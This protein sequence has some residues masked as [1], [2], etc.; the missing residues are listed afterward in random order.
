MKTAARWFWVVLALCLACDRTTLVDGKAHLLVD[1]DNMDFGWYLV[2]SQA[3]KE[4]RLTNDGNTPLTLQDWDVTGASFSADAPLRTRL[5]SGESVVMAV[6]FSAMQAGRAEGTLAVRSSSNPVLVLLEGHAETSCDD[7]NVCTEDALAVD[8]A[9]AHTPANGACDDHSICTTLDRCSLG[10]CVGQLLNCDDGD[11]CTED[12]CGP[13]QGCSHTQETCDDDNRCT[14][15]F[16]EASTGCTHVPVSDGN[17]C[18][19]EP[20][21]CH[22]VGECRSG[23]CVE[24]PVL[25]GTQCSSGPCAVNGLCQ[26]GQC[27]GESPLDCDD[28]DLCTAD[29][30]DG[31]GGCSHLPITCYDSNPCTADTC[32]PEGGC[33]FGPVP[34]GA[35][36]T[37][38]A[39]AC[40]LGYQCKGGQCGAIFEN[41][42]TSCDDGFWCTQDTM[43]QAGHCGN[44]PETVETLSIYGSGEP[45]VSAD[46]RLLV[47]SDADLDVYQRTP[48]GYARVGTHSGVNT[49]G[50]LW[51]KAPD[52]PVVALTGGA[53]SV[54]PWA[55]WG[56]GASGDV[57]RLGSLPRSDDD[58]ALY[59]DAMHAWLFE[60][61][62][63]LGLNPN[64]Q[65]TLAIRHLVTGSVTDTVALSSPCEGVQV[66]ETRKQVWVRLSLGGVAVVQV[67][68]AGQVTGVRELNTEDE[69]NDVA[70]SPN[71][72][73]VLVTRAWLGYVGVELYDPETLALVSATPVEEPFRNVQFLAPDVLVATLYEASAA[74]SCAFNVAN[75][76]AWA[77]MG[78]TWDGLPYGARLVGD[79]LMEYF[80]ATVPRMG[81]VQWS[82]NGF[83]RT[84]I[85]LLGALSMGPLG[86]EGQS[87]ALSVSADA[88]LQVG[89]TPTLHIT[90]V[91]VPAGRMLLWTDP[92]HTRTTNS[93]T[94]LWS[95]ARTTPPHE[96]VQED[97]LELQRRTQWSYSQWFARG[98]YAY[99]AVPD[100][101]SGLQLLTYALDQVP[102]VG[103]WMWQQT[104]RLDTGAA[105]PYYYVRGNQDPASGVATGIAAGNN[106][107]FLWTATPQ[108]DGSLAVATGVVPGQVRG[109]RAPG[110]RPWLLAPTG[111][112]GLLL[113][114][115]QA[116]AGVL[117]WNAG[118]GVDADDIVGG[119]GASVYVMSRDHLLSVVSV[120]ADGLPAVTMTLALAAQIPDLPQGVL[121]VVRLGNRLLLA[122]DRRVWALAAPCLDP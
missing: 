31:N 79:V 22:Q 21:A 68:E 48:E 9:C 116:Q 94:G 66:H 10:Q 36:C 57:T 84:Q 106:G 43:C 17:Q 33:A 97:V 122:S 120:G 20:A 73:A 71:A 96:V 44:V 65:H 63:Q 34:D 13:V 58:W 19:Q 113:Y 28:N 93:R 1:P 69:V 32:S 70:L 55:T 4:V 26:Q 7:D 47:K 80:S 76:A 102:A 56:N 82:G 2:G 98:Q 67:N 91:A 61:S 5:D 59:H 46:G 52:T 6:W 42:G 54:E 119:D 105:T 103:P 41:D 83:S 60:C 16:C 24:P 111:S 39:Q 117:I 100:P 50:V 114:P 115:V 37:G 27:T 12:T 51:V 107:T 72:V 11:P 53:P 64:N 108:P 62:A 49:G 3:R 8:G 121:T 15:D 29:A 95:D 110:G 99:R 40:V 118:V 92:Q 85:P 77:L 14:V 75:P 78:C 109:F 18:T 86:A 104:Q 87:S 88:V 81:Q 90:T 101:P 30:C 25:D 45:A 112:A 74:R 23:Q 89:L 38:P 35:E